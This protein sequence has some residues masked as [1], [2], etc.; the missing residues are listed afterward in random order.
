MTLRILPAGAITPGVHHTFTDATLADLVANAPNR[1]PAL[2][3]F[4]F[5]LNYAHANNRITSVDLTVRLTIDMPEWTEVGQRPQAEQDEW[6]RFLRAV[7][8]HED[9]HIEIFRRE[10]PKSYRRLLRARPG[11]INDVR[12]AEETRIEALSDAYD[13]RTDHG[14]RQ[15]TPHGNTVITVPP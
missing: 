9:G 14:R 1:E 7:R 10:A 5:D 4:H 6:N 15:Q 8:G 12:T 13:H 2:A 11:T 3:E